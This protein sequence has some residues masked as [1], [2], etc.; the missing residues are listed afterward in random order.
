MD[1]HPL[2]LVEQTNDEYHAGPGVSKS[3]LDAIAPPNSPLHYW[4]HYLNPERVREEDDEKKRHYIVGSATHCAILEPAEF[5]LRYACPPAGAPRRPTITQINAK[6]PSFDTMQALDWWKEFEFNTAGKII[7]KRDE[8]DQALRMRDAVHG[9]P[10]ARGL[11]VDG[12]AEKSFYDIDQESKLLVKVKPDWWSRTNIIVDVKTT[13]FIGGDD[14]GKTAHSHRYHVSA[15]LTLDVL[16]GLYDGAPEYYVCLVVEKSEPHDV[17]VYFIEQHDIERGRRDYRL[18][19]NLL[20]K[21]HKENRWPGA[22]SEAMPLRF[23]PW[24]K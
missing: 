20:A 22:C 11:L 15:S 24:A 17:G 6:N 19:L 14:F 4:H 7:L 2:G 13:A 16:Q 3:H 21:C 9:H 8:W 5:E 10:T 1:N 18:D 12:A 23:P